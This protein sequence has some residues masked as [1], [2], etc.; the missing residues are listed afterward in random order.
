MTKRK[1]LKRRVRRRT[2]K[3]GESYTAALRHLRAHTE[4]KTTMPSSV[5]TKF[6]ASCSFCKKA[7][8]QVRKL[9]AGPGV[10]ICDECIGLCNDIIGDGDA[11]AASETRAPALE[12]APPERL[13]VIFTGMAETART[14]EENLAYW[15]RALKE[16]GVSGER[17]A[18]AVGLTEAEATQRFDL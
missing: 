17:L 2:A 9:I 7:T 12:D 16:R 3:T 15:A 5:T 10:Y 11:P 14:M 1:H 13:L 6:T 4:E 8:D 18:T